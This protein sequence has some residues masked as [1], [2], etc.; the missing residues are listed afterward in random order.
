MVSCSG[1]EPC[2]SVASS[3]NQPLWS[4]LS[5]TFVVEIFTTEGGERRIK[6]I[7]KIA[8]QEEN[9]YLSCQQ[10]KSADERL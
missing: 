6:Q 5:L 2:S 8:L 3:L 7:K 4:A 1:V 10:E 9:I